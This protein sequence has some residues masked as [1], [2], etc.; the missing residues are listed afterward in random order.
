MYTAD[1]MIQIRNTAKPGPGKVAIIKDSKETKTEGGIFLPESTKTEYD[2]GMIVGVGTVLEDYPH[3]YQVGERA[4]VGKYA[5]ARLGTKIGEKE[6]EIWIMAADDVLATLA[7]DTK[8][9]GVQERKLVS[10]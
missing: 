8:V 5:G 3:D 4:F 1:E 7:E 9:Q 10:A 2:T 6:V